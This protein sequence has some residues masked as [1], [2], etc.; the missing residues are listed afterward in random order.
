MSRAS[1]GSRPSWPAERSLDSSNRAFWGGPAAPVARATFCVTKAGDG[2]T[3]PQSRDSMPMAAAAMIA[4]PCR[5]SGSTR[6]ASVPRLG[7]VPVLAAA[8]RSSPTVPLSDSAPDR[9]AA[10]PGR[11]GRRVVWAPARVHPGPGR[12]RVDTLHPARG[13]GEIAGA[14]SSVRAVRVDD[15]G[16]VSY[17]QDLTLMLYFHAIAFSKSA[18]LTAA[19]TS[20]VCVAAVRS[21]VG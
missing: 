18:S 17:S 6:T 1:A 4:L 12:G 14:P 5:L 11:L 21:A 2:Q 16:S 3:Q 7:P 15:L 9:L 8:A 20:C 13:K 19:L 10:L